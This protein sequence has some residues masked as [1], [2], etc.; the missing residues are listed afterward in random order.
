V[1]L[2]SNMKFL[3]GERESPTSHSLESIQLYLEVLVQCV[4]ICI[5]VAGQIMEV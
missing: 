5:R 2:I 1:Y 4:I 3:L